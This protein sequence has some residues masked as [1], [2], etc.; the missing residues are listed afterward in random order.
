MGLLSEVLSLLRSLTN[1]DEQEVN[2]DELEEKRDSFASELKM[3]ERDLDHIERNFDD[4]I[5]KARS[6]ENPAQLYRE[7]RN[8]LRQFRQNQA[9]YESIAE[10]YV[11]LSTFITVANQYE[12]VPPASRG[13]SD[14]LSDRQREIIQK[15]RQDQLIEKIP[16]VERRRLDVYEIPNEYRFDSEEFGSGFVGLDHGLY[17][18]SRVE[19]RTPWIDQIANAILADDDIEEP[20]VRSLQDG[21]TDASE[22]DDRTTDSR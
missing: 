17:E 4:T 11:M 9:K 7:A 8:I 20:E 1:S 16:I 5:E 18:Q 2:I 12:H 21:C 13:K 10:E 6:S 15:L 14:D 22:T 19:S 3:L